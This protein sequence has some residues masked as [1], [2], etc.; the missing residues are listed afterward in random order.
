M[1]LIFVTAQAFSRPLHE[2]SR[3]LPTYRVRIKEEDF[4]PGYFGK[5]LEDIGLDCFEDV[6]GG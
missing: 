6:H 5:Y 2:R 4:H 3:R 1:H